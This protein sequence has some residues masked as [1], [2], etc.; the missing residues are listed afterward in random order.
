MTNSSFVQLEMIPLR[1][2]WHRFPLGTFQSKRPTQTRYPTLQ[3]IVRNN[4]KVKKKTEC[5]QEKITPLNTASLHGNQ[6]AK[7]NWWDSLSG[8]NI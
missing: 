7:K 1:R 4:D 5:I 3:K 2:L 6:R 8:F